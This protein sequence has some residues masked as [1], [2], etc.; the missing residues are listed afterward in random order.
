MSGHLKNGDCFFLSTANE[1]A[2]SEVL[3]YTVPQVRKSQK[4]EPIFVLLSAGFMALYDGKIV[5]KNVVS[6]E[7]RQ[8]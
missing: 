8:I 4:T 7:L 1:P 3:G 5:F 6:E 2:W